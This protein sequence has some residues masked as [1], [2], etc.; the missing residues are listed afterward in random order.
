MHVAETPRPQLALAKSKAE[1][2]GAVNM[3][4]VQ[5]ERHRRVSTLPRAR[6]YK[7]QLVQARESVSAR[8]GKRLDN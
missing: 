7:D 4:C 2:L 8:R 3:R 1:E 6:R 5:G